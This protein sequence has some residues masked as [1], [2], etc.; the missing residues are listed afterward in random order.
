[1]TGSLQIIISGEPAI[2]YDKGL[3]RVGISLV[4]RYYARQCLLGNPL[5]FYPL[6]VTEV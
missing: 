2:L 5:Q 1:M 3:A 4:R 6:F